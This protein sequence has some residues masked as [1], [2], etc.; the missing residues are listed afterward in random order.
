MVQS[1]LVVCIGNICRSPMAVGLLRARLR[2]V[3]VESAGLGA[4]IGHPADRIA[5]ELM[6]ERDIVIDDHRARP[7]SASLCAQSDV[8]FVMDAKQKQSVVDRYPTTRGKVFR[9]GEFIDQDIFDPY[10][11][12]RSDFQACLTLIDRAIEDWVERL[13]IVA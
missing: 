8:I 7:L 2:H 1:V 9:L 6:R 11:G 3:R 13:K 10:G 4:L 5:R 12:E